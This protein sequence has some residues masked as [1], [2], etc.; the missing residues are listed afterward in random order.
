MNKAFRYLSQVFLLFFVAKF[1]AIAMPG[2]QYVDSGEIYAK[3]YG[4]IYLCRPC[5][6]WVGMHEGTNEAFGPV[7]TA[8]LRQLKMLAHRW[9]DQ[10]A[11][12][13]LINEF[14]HVYMAG[15]STRAKAYHWLA[16]EMGIKPEFCHIGMFDVEQC[17]QVIP[18]CQP[19][20]E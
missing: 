9:F 3:T 19:I 4:M 13:G 8:K 15:L 7:P 14:Y 2:T 6:A 20:V 16:S 11:V 17:K 10:L 18:I 1:V 5:N 12:E